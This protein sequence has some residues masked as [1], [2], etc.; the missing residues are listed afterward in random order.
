[1]TRIRQNSATVVDSCSK[2]LAAL[3]QYVS[4]SKATIAINGETYKVSDVIAMYQECLDT[5]ATLNTQRAQVK[6]T[7]A[8]RSAAETQRQAADRALKPWVINQYGANSQ[9]AHDFGFPPPK[10]PARTADEK[11]QTA[12]LSLATR[13]AR[14]TM[15]SK[16]K[17]SIKG[18]I[19]APTAPAAPANNV[20]PVAQ[21]TVAP[22]AANVA[23]PVNG[24]ATTA[25]NGTAAH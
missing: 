12:A 13:E 16:Q 23:A 24:A 9:Q 17:K 6:A 15:G 1:M 21:A 8:S 10:V 18:T 14:H 7:M 19:V 4:T 20:V 2:R 22:E 3:K 5:R 25:V 11:A